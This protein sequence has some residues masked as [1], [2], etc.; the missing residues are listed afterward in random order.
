MDCARSTARFQASSD[1]A[2]SAS[3]AGVKDRE[4]RAAQAEASRKDA[5][6]RRRRRRKDCGFRISDVEFGKA[7]FR[8]KRLAG[9]LLDRASANAI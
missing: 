6:K 7:D 5:R 4:R 1:A 3:A 8:R 2:T 9:I